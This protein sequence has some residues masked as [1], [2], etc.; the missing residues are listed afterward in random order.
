M[1]GLLIP[2]FS[3]LLIYIVVFILL[4]IGWLKI[5]SFNN[6]ATPSNLIVSV[7]IP[8]RN[9][10]AN[11]ASIIND[12]KDQVLPSHLY[13]AIFVNDHSEDDSYVIVK[14]N[15]NNTSSFR[16]LNLTGDKTGKK[17]AIYHG[18]ESAKGSLIVT[19][20]ADCR[21]QPG[22]LQTISSYYEQHKPKLIIGPVEFIS[23][24]GFF[25]RFQQME[26]ASLIG[27]SA[28]A[29]ALGHPAMCNGANLAFEKAAYSKLSDPTNKNF[30]S[31][32]DIFLLQKIKKK[33]KKD[34]HFIK[35]KNAVVRTKASPNL[36][37]FINQRKRWLSKSSGYTDNDIRILAAVVY[38]TSLSILFSFFLGFI[39]PIYSLWGLA[40][41]VAKTMVDGLLFSS[42]AQYFNIKR[43]ILLL[44]PF[45]IIYIIYVSLMPVFFL[46][47]TFIWKNRVFNK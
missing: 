40:S 26:L 20:D 5:P 36:S 24:K 19:T 13:E 21:L 7:I 41:F 12:L 38:L 11:L 2:T 42:I 46:K 35:H 16:L 34:I 14:S 39:K 15:I 43:N 9:E 33:Y 47:K 30:A 18:I 4:Y 3:F 10:A 28:G 8:F 32:D 23:N 31:G 22:W 45:Q 37:L 17:A 25:N 44:V 29:T 1:P 27:S 6:S